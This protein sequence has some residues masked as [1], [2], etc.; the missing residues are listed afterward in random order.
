VP[1]QISLLGFDDYIWN[2]YFS[3]SITAVAQSTFE[4]GKRSFELLQQIM[5]R[6]K[7]EDLP[8]KH[9]RLA[10]ELRVR[11]SSAR[12]PKSARP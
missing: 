1:Q 9:I 11:N 8:E 12:P 7:G 3:P 4:M 10:A 2:R 5:N 6:K